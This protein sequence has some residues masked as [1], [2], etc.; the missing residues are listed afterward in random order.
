MLIG[1]A[2]LSTRPCFDCRLLRLQNDEQTAALNWQV[3]VT[4]FRWRVGHCLTAA[5]GSQVQSSERHI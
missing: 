3:H 1:A 4:H 5:V 2:W